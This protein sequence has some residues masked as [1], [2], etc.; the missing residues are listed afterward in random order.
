MKPSI[1]IR[2]IA[3][4][5]AI[6]PLHEGSYK[7]AGGKSVDAFDST[8]V[9]VETECG[10]TGYGECC[11]LGSSYIPAFPEGTRAGIRLL[12]PDLLGM[13]PTNLSNVNR[14]M[15]HCLKGHS[16]SKSAIDMACWDIFGKVALF[17]ACTHHMPPCPGV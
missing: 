7:W 13:D 9:G 16:S 8:I 10:V 2:R 17:S 1:R 11:P 4:Y 5:R 12:A 15:D 3:I 14:K 6:L